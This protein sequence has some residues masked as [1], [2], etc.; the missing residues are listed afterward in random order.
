MIGPYQLQL[1]ARNSNY[2]SGGY[3]HSYPFIRPFIGVIIPVITIVVAQCVKT[4]ALSGATSLR[5][6]SNAEK[7]F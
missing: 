2:V 4:S 7:D 1:R 6:E 3:N 5:F